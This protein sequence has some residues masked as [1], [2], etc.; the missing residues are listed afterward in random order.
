MNIGIMTMHRVRNLGSFLQAYGLK[1]LIEEQGH[2]V[3]FVDIPQGE[4]LPPRPDGSDRMSRGP[5]DKLRKL[6][7]YLRIRRYRRQH[8]DYY[9]GPF[10]ESLRSHLNLTPQPSFGSCDVLV[11]GS[12]EMFNCLNPDFGFTLAP[13]GDYP[14]AGKVISYAA[15]CGWTRYD[16]LTPEQAEA[17]R[18]AVQN[19]SARSVRDANTADFLSHLTEEPILRHLDP[20]LIYEFPDFFRTPAV[21]PVSGDYLLVY[22]YQNRIADKS[23]I[24]AIRRFARAHGCKTVALGAPQYWCDQYLTVPPEEVLSCFQQARYVVTDTFH[25]AILSIKS[26]SQFAALVRQSNRNKLQCLLEELGLSDRIVGKD[27]LEDCLLR[28]VDYAHTDG[29]IAAERLRTRQYLR[30]NLTSL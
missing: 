29:I 4:P 1:R 2:R 24:N 16:L 13:F 5:G 21:P 30:D 23:E 26:H 11:V 22:G 10:Q 14:A 3:E 6:P 18:G 19:L 25:G 8:A 28:P 20:V 7:Y 12:D 15:S 9:S 27:S 17:L